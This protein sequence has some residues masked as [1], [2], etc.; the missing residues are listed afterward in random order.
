MESARKCF[1]LGM[2]E[3]ALRGDAVLR[4]MWSFGETKS[5][6]MGC[7]PHYILRKVSLE[8]SALFPMVHASTLFRRVLA[9]VMEVQRGLNRGRIEAHC[10]SNNR[11]DKTTSNYNISKSTVQLIPGDTCWTEVNP[12]RGEREIESQWD[13]ED[14][15][16][17]CQVANGPSSYETKRLSGRVKAPHQDGF[18]QVATPRVVSTALCQNE[19]ANADLTTCSALTESTPLECDIDLP[20]NN[21]EER[22]S[23]CS[24]SLSPR[25]RVYGIRRS[26]YGVVPSTAMKDNRDGRTNVPATMNLT[27]YRQCTS[28]LAI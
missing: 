10:S 18:F 28:K 11:R 16:I 20:R 6:E 3:S 24:T 9:Y 14:Y 27:E 8:P 17:T 12:F 19:Y 2:Q 23:Q 25:G 22:L 15:E 13:K 1:N 5:A 7:Y 4:W 21:M 26:L